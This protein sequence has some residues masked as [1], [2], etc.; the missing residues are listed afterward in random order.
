[1]LLVLST[2]RVV[3][4]FR[5]GL[6]MMVFD[7][8]DSNSNVAEVWP[9]LS[10]SL[11]KRRAKKVDVLAPCHCYVSGFPDILFLTQSMCYHPW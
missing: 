5:A 9:I 4:L 11:P 2:I 6:Q 10:Q 7:P 1:M 3:Q 8:A